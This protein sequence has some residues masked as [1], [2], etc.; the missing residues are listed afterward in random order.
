MGQAYV[1]FARNAMDQIRS[2]VTDELWILN[3]FEVRYLLFDFYMIFQ[4][5]TKV[6]SKFVILLFF[7]TLWIAMVHSAS[8]SSL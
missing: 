4:F 3:F 8:A 2:K 7:S 5:V 1:N 6:D